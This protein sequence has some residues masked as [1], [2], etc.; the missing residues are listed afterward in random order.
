MKWTKEAAIEEL[1]NLAGQT[2]A[3]QQLK[4]NCEEHIRWIV[5][6][7]RFL[8]EIF[9]EESTYF[10]TFASFTWSKQG[11]YMIGGPARPNESFNPQLGV[12]R[13]NQEAYV[14]ELGVARGLLLAAK[15]ELEEKEINEVYK[16]KN[17]E[18][19]TSLI[20]KVINLAE[21]KLRKVIRKEPSGEKEVQDAFESLLVGADISF[22]RESERIEYSSKTY[23]P[24]FTMEKAG[25]AVE[26]KFCNRNGREKEIIA[27]I[28]DDILAYKTKYGNI[29]FIV[30][31]VGC[32]RDIEKFAKN[33]EDQEG[34]VVRVVKH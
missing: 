18:P 16:G 34:V 10:A 9:G 11:G 31:D 33:F 15:D 17:T 8:T 27:E 1:N 29:V 2:N 22:S 20:L 3:L 26:I 14:K 19:E 12:E 13:V 5:K 7:R 32:I 28:N 21:H 4:R 24:D 30:Y 25:L 23:T 6:T